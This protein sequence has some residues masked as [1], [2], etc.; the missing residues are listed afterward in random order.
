LSEGGPQLFDEWGIRKGMHFPLHFQLRV[1]SING[2]N[3]ID[4]DWRQ[5]QGRKRD[6]FGI[7]L[8]AVIVGDSS[9]PFEPRA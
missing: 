9:H 4:F 8:Q 1:F 7:N 2:P 3:F 5:C 6:D